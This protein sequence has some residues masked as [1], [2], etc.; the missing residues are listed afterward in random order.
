MD[1]EDILVVKKEGTDRIKFKVCDRNYNQWSPKKY[2][3]VIA[4][5]DFNLLAYLFY[6]LHSMGFPI[7]KAH[8]KFKTLLNEPD[9]F[10]LR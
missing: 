10:F 8:L 7:D 6:D 2:E 5:K 4:S 9:L 3:K 1:K